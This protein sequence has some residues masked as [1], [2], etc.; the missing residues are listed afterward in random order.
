RGKVVGVQGTP[1]VGANV[2]IQGT[3]RATATDPARNFVFTQVPE[4]AIIVISYIG[5]KTNE[6]KASEI[7]SVV[8]LEDSWQ[9]LSD[10]EIRVAYGTQTKQSFSGTATVINAEEIESKPRV[11]FTESLQ[12]K[13]PG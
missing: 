8:V 6:V 9:R 7:P 2:S 4:D 3:R 5:Y 10:V 1:L 11:T 13:V 12:G